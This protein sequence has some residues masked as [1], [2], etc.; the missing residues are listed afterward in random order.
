M[1]INSD[2]SEITVGSDVFTIGEYVNV[3]SVLSQE[4]LSGVIT[5]IAHNEIIVRLGTAGNTAGSRV[6]FTLAHLKSGRVV[7]S[8]DTETIEQNELLL[9][10]AS[11]GLR[12]NSGGAG[13]ANAARLAGAALRQQQTLS[14]TQSQIKA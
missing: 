2:Y 11:N 12:P 3:F 5:A 6:S 9:R 10:G 7:L 14:A 4:T 13:S 1:S 8:R